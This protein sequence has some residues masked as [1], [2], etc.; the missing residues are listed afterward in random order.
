MEFAKYVNIPFSERGSSHQG[1][2][3][4]GLVRLW[5]REQMGEDLPSYDEFY[6]DTEDLAAAHLIQEVKDQD[7]WIPLEAGTEKEGDVILLRIK[8]LPWHI[9][10]VAGKG[11]MLHVE[12]GAESVIEPYNGLKWNKRIIGFYRFQPKD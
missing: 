1:C 8:G 7:Q 2:N 5:K 11:R 9:G 6:T 3:C 4:W 10:V 12:L